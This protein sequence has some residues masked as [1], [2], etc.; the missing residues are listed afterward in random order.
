[1]HE[2]V[3]VTSLAWVFQENLEDSSILDADIKDASAAIF[4]NSL[5]HFLIIFL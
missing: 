2:F 1:M 5:D 4:I 3:S